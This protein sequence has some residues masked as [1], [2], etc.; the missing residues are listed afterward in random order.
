MLDLGYETETIT[1]GKHNYVMGV[2]ENGI[3]ATSVGKETD[4]QGKFIVLE[5]TE[6]GGSISWHCYGDN[7]LEK[8]LPPNCR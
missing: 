6:E 2:Y 7:V 4:S 1:V 5:P 3:I 8:H